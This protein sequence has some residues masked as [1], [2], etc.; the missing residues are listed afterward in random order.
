MESIICTHSICDMYGIYNL[1]RHSIY[2]MYGIYNLYIFRSAF[3]EKVGPGGGCELCG[4][5]PLEL[6]KNT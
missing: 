2:N 4:H 1:Y 5:N 3:V 6:G